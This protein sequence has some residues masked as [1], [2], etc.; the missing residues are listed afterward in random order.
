VRRSVDSGQALDVAFVIDVCCRKYEDDS[1]DA[2]IVTYI[3]CMGWKTRFEQI[4]D[5]GSLLPCHLISHIQLAFATF[6]PPNNRV[7]S[8]DTVVIF[9]SVLCRCH[10]LR[11]LTKPMYVVRS[12]SRYITWRLAAWQKLLFRDRI[13]TLTAFCFKVTAWS[14][15]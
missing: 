2:S 6:F 5:V 7:E 3:N 11:N 4:D 14:I 8:D 1:F 10:F 12:L 9:R 15:L 13:L